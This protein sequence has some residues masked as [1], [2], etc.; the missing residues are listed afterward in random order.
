MIPKATKIAL[1]SDF[2][3]FC[4][5]DNQHSESIFDLEE[6]EQIRVQEILMLKGTLRPKTFR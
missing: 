1:F 4:S 6:P 3:S 5:F 2:R